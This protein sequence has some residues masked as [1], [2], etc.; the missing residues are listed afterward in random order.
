MIATEITVSLCQGVK[1]GCEITGLTWTL[2]CSWIRCQYFVCANIRVYDL[3]KDNLVRFERS[4]ELNFLRAVTLEK[5]I[6]VRRTSH[7]SQDIINEMPPR[8]T[9]AASSCIFDCTI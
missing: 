9:P 4:L 1:G 5:H 6:V 8:I 2:R 7:F 3:C